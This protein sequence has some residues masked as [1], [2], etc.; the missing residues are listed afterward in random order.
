MTTCSS[1]RATGSERSPR[2]PARALAA[3]C[4]RLLPA[5][6]ADPEH[7]WVLC[8]LQTAVIR[9]VLVLPRRPLEVCGAVRRAKDLHHELVEGARLDRDLREMAVAVPLMSL[10]PVAHPDRRESMG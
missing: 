9:P 2:R 7:P 6:G 1:S 3:A 8:R 4:R 5:M 10:P